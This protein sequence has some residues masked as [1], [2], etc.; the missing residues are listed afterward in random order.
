MPRKYHR[1]PAVKRRKAKKTSYLYP[2]SPEPEAD[3]DTEVSAAPDELDE[4]EWEETF[5][6]GG[7]KGRAATRHLVKDYSYVRS[8]VMRI[9]GLA[10]FLV[11]SLTL[12]AVLRG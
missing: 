3:E 2:G 4:E 12:T 7:A 9:L 11:I 1:P 6:V 5:P 10:A 8:E